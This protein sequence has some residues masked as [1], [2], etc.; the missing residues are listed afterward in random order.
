MRYFKLGKYKF[1]KICLGTWSLG[2]NKNKNI[3]YGSVSDIKAKKILNYAYDK[4]VNFFDTAN[5]YGDSEKK[6]GELFEKKRDKIFIANKVGCVSFK[7]KLNFSKNVVEKQFLCSLKN[8][9]TDY[10]DIVQL[11]CPNFEDKNLRHTIEYL[12]K[13]KASGKIRF[14][15]ISLARPSDYLQLRK[16]Y[17]FDTV[18]CNF[19]MLDHRLLENN[20]LDQLKKDRVKTFVRTILN[21]GIFTESFLKRDKIKFKKNDHRYYWNKDQIEKWALYANKIKKIT[22]RNIEGTGYKFVNSFKIDG[23]IIGAAS[24]DHLDQALNFKNNTKLS[25][26]EKINIKKIYKEYS[27]GFLIKPKIGMKRK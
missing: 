8:M 7:K 4:G 20:I 11:Y 17:N 24:K 13:L 1:S 6:L 10:M 15:G 12:D 25:F 2:G 16:L 26:K 27:D 14:I 22:K 19:N 5:V 9:R 23:L 18:Q 21:F 3:S